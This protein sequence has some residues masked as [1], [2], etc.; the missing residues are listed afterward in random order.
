[1]ISRNQLFRIASVPMIGL[2][3]GLCVGM[4]CGAGAKSVESGAVAA[5]VDCTTADR[6]K[7]EAQFGP[8]VE[9][10]IQ[11]ATGMDGKVDTPSL[12]QIG[13]ALEADGWCVL[14]TEA[15]KLIAWVGSKVG[16]ASAPAPLDAAD[17][18][19]QVAKMRVQKFGATQFQLK[20]GP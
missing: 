8:T 15:A 12:Q 9:Q 5:A 19:A 10:A 6:T 3:I 1:M 7:L 17:L 13:N 4:A 20:P 16:T 18:A 11:R 2:V 14:E